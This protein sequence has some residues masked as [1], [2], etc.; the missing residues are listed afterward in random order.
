MEPSIQASLGT[1][2]P[3]YITKGTKT[4]NLRHRDG[5]GNSAI[6]EP[7]AQIGARITRH[8]RN[9]FLVVR[10]DIH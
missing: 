9:L 3:R 5:D 6:V 8:L 2:K 4:R 7:Y 10:E 1:T